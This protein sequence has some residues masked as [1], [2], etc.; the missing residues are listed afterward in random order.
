MLPDWWY[1]NRGGVMPY[2]YGHR[3]DA[4]FHRIPAS[5]RFFLL[6][7]VTSLTDLLT[8]LPPLVLSLFCLRDHPSRTYIIHLHYPLSQDQ[9][10]PQ[11]VVSIIK[12]SCPRLSAY[13]IASRRL[14]HLSTHSPP[15]PGKLCSPAG[16]ILTSSCPLR[17]ERRRVSLRARPFET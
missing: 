3:P 14:L 13:L 8:N 4:A 17:I 15:L 16:L 9:P 5:A 11:L 1:P 6:S 10:Q 12:L 2:E 7:H